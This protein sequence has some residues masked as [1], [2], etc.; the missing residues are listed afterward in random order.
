MGT[1]AKGEWDVA[2][3]LLVA[4]GF[5][6]AFASGLLGIGGGVVLVP[7]ALYLPPLLGVASYS[8]V[9]VVGMSMVQVLV[10]STLSL[11]AHA[12]RGL[13]PL[14]L[15]V[16]LGAAVGLGAIAGGFASAL[17]S[18]G[19]LRIVFA[20]LAIIASI[21]MLVPAKGVSEGTE[22]PEG[23]RIDLAAILAFGVGIA[24][25]MVGIGGGVLMIPLLTTVFHLPIRLVIGTSTA[26]VFVAGL[27]GTLGKALNHQIPWESAIFLVA[28][29]LVGAPLGA[30][31]SHRLPVGVL[32]KLLAA[33]IVVTA[34]KMVYELF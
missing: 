3:L 8:M 13:V 2:E 25:G 28:G 18:E 9:Q 4:I 7:M 6:G 12:R 24:S 34:V 32:R 1:D 14:Q 10:A 20:T 17:V 26:V 15:A 11:Q 22:L 30:K 16:P 23:F 19:V 5:V 21:L 33:T 31:A 27:M 29:V